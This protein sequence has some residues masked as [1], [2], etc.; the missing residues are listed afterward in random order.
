MS[1]REY[2]FEDFP[3]QDLVFALSRRHLLTGLVTQMQVVRGQDEGRAAFSLAKLGSAP[4]ADLAALI[5]A[6]QP[7][8]EISLTADFVCG[9]LRVTADRFPLFPVSPR[10]SRHSTA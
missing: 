2:A 6:I 10:A 1:S 9:K 4:D 7:E 5:P 8:C 3:R